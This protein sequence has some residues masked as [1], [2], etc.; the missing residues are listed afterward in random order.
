MQ[1]HV[2]PTYWLTPAALFFPGYKVKKVIQVTIWKDKDIQTLTNFQFHKFTS[3]YVIMKT[4]QLVAIHNVELQP[5][6][7]IIKII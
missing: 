2:V 6:Y 4:G 3:T 1:S 7:T 5:Q